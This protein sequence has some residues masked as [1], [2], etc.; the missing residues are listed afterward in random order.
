MCNDRKPRIGLLPLMLELYDEAAPE[1]KPKQAKFAEEIAKAL[2]DDIQVG[3]APVCN[4]RG[5][6][7]A[8]VED[9]E[10]KRLDGIIVVHLSY[11]PSLISA[12]ALTRTSLPVLLLDTTPAPRLDEN[13]T[14]ADIMENHGIHGVQDLA[15]ILLR[16]D[17]TYHIVAGHILNPDIVQQ[18]KDWCRAAMTLRFWRRMR[19]GL[20]G[21]PFEGMGD[22]SV[23]LT[24]FKLV[25]GP[26]VTQ[27]PVEEVVK[28]AKAASDDEVEAEMAADLERFQPADDLDPELHAIAVRAGLGLRKAIQEYELDALSM[29][30]MAFNNHPDIG[31]VPFLEISK[32]ISKGMG[33]AGE[34][35]VVCAS[36]VAA[37]AC[38]FDRASF[39]EMFCP[40]WD[41]G[42]VLM[43]HMG[44]CNPDLA[45]EKAILKNVPFKF[46]RLRGTTIALAGMAPGPATLVDLC[47]VGGD[48]YRLIAGSVEVADF[49]VLDI[50]MPHYKIDPL[51]PLGEFLIRYSELGGTHHLAIVP[52]DVVEQVGVLAD[53]AD[54]DFA[55]I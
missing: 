17:K 43:A 46:G 10:A 39:T 3:S 32:L 27:V 18:V 15:N 23:D 25:I 1:L 48:M 52:G 49:P 36:L 8:A 41:G 45:A 16:A 50:T 35:D 34:G 13:L 55:V 40:D 38:Q 7:E 37:M 20:I 11:A 19:V 24:A 54:L 22:F 51:M 21:T 9:F 12:N 30:F 44:E 29:H 5:Q 2:G 42:K 28:L 4:T 33:Y 31:T 26:E 6:V 53:L 14:P 47:C